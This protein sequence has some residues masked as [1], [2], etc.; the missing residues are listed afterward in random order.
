MGG[1]FIAQ[2]SLPDWCAW[3]PEIVVLRWTYE[4]LMDNEY[5]GR[6]LSCGDSPA[7]V[8]TGEGVLQ[9]YGIEDA[10]RATSAAN[11]VYIALGLQALAFGLLWLNKTRYMSIKHKP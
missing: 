6:T 4:G 10:D 5:S 9:Q 1:F 3:I 8:P 11:L 7:C 2:D